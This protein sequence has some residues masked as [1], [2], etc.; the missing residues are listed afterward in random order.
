MRG[1]F[2]EVLD[3]PALLQ[4][5]CKRMDHREVFDRPGRDSNARDSL[6]GRRERGEERE[7]KMLHGVAEF[8]TVRSVPGINGIERFKL[9]DAGA[10]GDAH[11]IQRGV[12]KRPD[13][14]GEADQ[15]QHRARSPDFGI[16]GAGGFQSGER[17]NDV[18][19]RPRPDQKATTGDKIACPTSG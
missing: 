7:R 13:P 17:K 15:G 9:R 19:D 18:A 6:G 16:R 14:I 8:R 4:I 10:F 12:R 2:F 11:Q 5:T 3:R 1:H